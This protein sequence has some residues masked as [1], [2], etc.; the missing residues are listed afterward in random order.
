MVCLPAKGHAVAIPHDLRKFTQLPQ[1]PSE[2]GIILIKSG[3]NNSKAYFACRERVQE[4]LDGLIFGVPKYGE[5]TQKPGY[6]CYTG[7]DHVSGVALH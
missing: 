1:L 7:K 2:V 6:T 5:S 3:K 4:A